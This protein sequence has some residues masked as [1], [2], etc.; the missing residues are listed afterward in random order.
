MIEPVFVGTAVLLRGSPFLSEKVFEKFLGFKKEFEGE[1]RII[2]YM[3]ERMIGA[4][5]SS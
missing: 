5:F 1:F 4:H 2:E 3:T